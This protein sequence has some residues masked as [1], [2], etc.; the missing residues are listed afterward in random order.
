MEQEKQDRISRYLNERNRDMVF[1][2]LRDDFLK[3]IGGLQ[4]LRGVPVPVNEGGSGRISVKDIIMDMARV[5]GSDPGF[6]YAEKYISYIRNVAAATKT[7]AADML[8]TEGAR[9]ADAGDYEDACMLFRAALRFDPKNRS[10]MYL[11]ARSCKACS[12]TAAE[13][14][15]GEPTPEGEEYIGKFK[16]ESLEMFELLTMMHP[17]FAMGYYFLGYGYLNLGL[18]LK[19][20]LTW[21]DFL[22]LSSSAEENDSPEMDENQLDDL[23]HEISG[24]LLDLEEPVRIEEGCNLIMSGDYQGGMD[25]LNDFREGRYENWW[26]LWYY[27]GVA[28]SSLGH[29]GEAAECYKRV[30]RLSP[31]NTDAME[32]LAAIYALSGDEINAAKYRNKIKIVKQNQMLDSE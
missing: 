27:L 30:L 14:E 23:R 2:E 21:E 7:D 17:D 24:M 15:A 31:S 26:P 10:A 19:A 13:N 25:I 9:S 22:R 5:V 32:E 8:V 6:L 20:K 16:A 29:P 18:Y 1:G 12:E 4:I 3:S 11:Y 28:E